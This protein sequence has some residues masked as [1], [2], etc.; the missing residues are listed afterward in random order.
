[1]VRELSAGP[2]YLQVRAGRQARTTPPVRLRARHLKSTGEAQQERLR[3]EVIG[4][5][6]VH[7]RENAVEDSCVFPSG[8]VGWMQHNL[9]ELALFE[10]L[11]SCLGVCVELSWRRVP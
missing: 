9:P 2:Q 7:G 1:M 5:K 3:N 4:H 11:L 10:F 8:D 6:K